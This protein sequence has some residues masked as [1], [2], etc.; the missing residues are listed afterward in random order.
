MPNQASG[1]CSNFKNTQWQ[2]K[3]VLRQ[4]DV[5]R[6]TERESEYLQL[7]LITKP[8][9]NSIRGHMTGRETHTPHPTPH[10]PHPM[11]TSTH[12]CVY[13]CTHG[14]QKLMASVFLDC[15]P[16]SIRRQSF[17]LEPRVW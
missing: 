14:G 13:R 15:F 17:S 12:R 5:E 3:V 10:T 16:P 8:D 6:E 2:I 4:T 11:H 1:F 7:V 9:L